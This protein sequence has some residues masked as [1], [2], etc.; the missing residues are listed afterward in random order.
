MHKEL[1]EI[2]FNELEKDMKMIYHQININKE[3]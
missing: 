1:N 3:K 2:M